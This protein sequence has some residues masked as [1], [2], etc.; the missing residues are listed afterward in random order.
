MITNINLHLTSFHVKRNVEIA[1]RHYKTA[2]CHFSFK[3]Q[4]RRRKQRF[5]PCRE[6]CF[7]IDNRQLGALPL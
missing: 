1:K 3:G 7:F 6:K 2:L 4:D 5:S